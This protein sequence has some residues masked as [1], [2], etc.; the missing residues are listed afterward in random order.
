[1]KNNPSIEHKYDGAKTTN[2]PSCFP[3]IKLCGITQ[4][5]KIGPNKMAQKEIQAIHIMGLRCALCYQI[6][7][8]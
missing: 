8:G 3:Q 5:M 1:M 2:A 6:Q 7:Y 4:K